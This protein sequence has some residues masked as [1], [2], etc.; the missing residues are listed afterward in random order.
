MKTNFKIQFLFW[1]F[2]L[3]ISSSGQLY[4]QKGLD[5]LLNTIDKAGKVA[6]KADETA[7]KT[8][9]VINTVKAITWKKDNSPNIHYEQVPDYRTKEEVDLNNK[10]KLKVENGTFRN[11]QWEP[12]VKFDNQIFPSFIIGWS[13][14]KGDKNVDMGSSLGFKIN[15]PLTGVVLKWEIECTDKSLFNIDS[16]YINCDYLKSGNN[17]MP[18]IS[19]NYRSLTK[20][21]SNV[22]VNIYFRLTDPNSGGK[23]EKLQTINLRSINDCIFRNNNETLDY[24]FASYVNEDFPEIDPI[25]REML[26]TKM[27]SSIVGYQSGTQQVIMQIAALWRVLNSKGFQYSSIT[28]NSGMGSREG[29]YS[30]SVRT[31]EQSLKTQQANCVDG[32]VLFASILKKIG[33]MPALIIVPGHCFLGFY[34]NMNKQEMMFLETTMLSDKTY[35][36]NPKATVAKYKPLLNKIIP[37]DEKLSELNQAYLL[38]LQAAISS[39]GKTYLENKNNPNGYVKVIDIAEWRSKIKP[40]PYYP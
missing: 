18:R 2:I 24:M 5:K 29:I 27:I 25:L 30:Q 13:N 11:L 36:S 15:T 4:G 10:Q 40:I 7:R 22:P 26:N 38:E 14:Y 12:V 1:L 8:G 6:D 39:G 31:I 23:V 21:F 37:A 9:K 33:I 3:M 28:D 16:G 34:T 19:W 35:I 17:F 32:S 20:Q